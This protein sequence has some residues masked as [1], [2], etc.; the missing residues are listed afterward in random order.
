MSGVLKS[1][2]IM[3]ND[4][5]LTHKLT[6]PTE[7]LILARNAELR[8]NRGA[9]R[10]LG[11]QSGGAFGRQVASIPMNLFHWA[12]KNGY[13]LNNRDSEIAGKEMMRFL[14]SEKGKPCL[15]QEKL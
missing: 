5:V 10:D 1:E 9:I 11:E 15:I 13:D 6:Q 12:V 8:K 7:D 4:G 14:Q 3:D 2:F